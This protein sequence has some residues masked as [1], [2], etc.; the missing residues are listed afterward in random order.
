[1]G[2]LVLIANDDFSGHFSEDE[3]PTTIRPPDA[4]LSTAHCRLSE[5]AQTHGLHLS[6]GSNNFEQRGATNNDGPFWG[7]GK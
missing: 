5:D 6:L 7:F 2:L 3:I 4:A 1:M